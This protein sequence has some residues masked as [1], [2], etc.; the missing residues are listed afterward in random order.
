MKLTI[1]NKLKIFSTSLLFLF[2]AVIAVNLYYS[3]NIETDAKLIKEQSLPTAITSYQLLQT[4][5]KIQA[6]ALK[7]VTKNIE[8]ITEFKKLQGDVKLELEELRILLGSENEV[9][10]TIQKNVKDYTNKVS[11]DV[12][13]LYNPVIENRAIENLMDW[14]ESVDDFVINI[15]DSY[16]GELTETLQNQAEALVIALNSYVNGVYSEKVTAEASLVQLKETLI[17]IN[18]DTKIEDSF[19]ELNGFNTSISAMFNEFNPTNKSTALENINKI[20]KKEYTT[21]SANVVSLFKLQQEQVNN[22]VSSLT[23]SLSTSTLVILTALISA[24]IFALTFSTLLSRSI[25]KGLVYTQKHLNHIKEGDLTGKII[26]SRNDE[27]GELQSDLKEMQEGLVSIMNSVNDKAL[28]LK[29]ASSQLNVITEETKGGTNTQQMEISMVAT[30]VDEMNATTQNISENAS[31]TLALT[32]LANENVSESVAKVHENNNAIESLSQN[33][34]ESSIFIKELE[35]SGAKIENIMT[36]ISAVTEQT[37]LLALNAA[38]EAARAGEAGRGFAV[39]ADE[40]RALASKTAQS[41]EEIKGIIDTIHSCTDKVVKSMDS[42]KE[43]AAIVQKISKE[44]NNNIEMIA[45]N[46]IDVNDK[47][48]EISSAT[49]Q[50]LVTV[51]EINRNVTSINDASTNINNLTDSLVESSTELDNTSRELED[52]VRKFKLS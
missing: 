36:V 9:F 22:N 6:S 5:E 47:N 42:S 14:E 10:L 43:K 44:V 49:E 31:N 46:I 35:E 27:F 3:N 1:K 41:T 51:E 37:N 7:H 4:K 24:L 2:S 39:V 52:T 25:N 17:L 33:M 40:V 15:E 45:S 19:S 34:E 8:A 26:V 30:A 18:E 16:E 21:F 28:V 23:D 12:F 29:E 48:T 11:K 38:I 32:Q 20:Q 13:E 50:Q